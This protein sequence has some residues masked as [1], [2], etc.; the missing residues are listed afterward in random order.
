MIDKDSAKEIAFDKVVNDF[1][2]GLVDGDE[3]IIPDEHSSALENGWRFYFTTKLFDEIDYGPM[4]CIIV[5]DHDGN[6]HYP[7][8]K[9]IY[10]IKK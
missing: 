1:G 2:K 7:P 3:F 8:A 10:D 5:V 6:A 4:I 9:S